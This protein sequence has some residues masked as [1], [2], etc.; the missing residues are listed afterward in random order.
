MGLSGLLCSL[1]RFIEN[2]DRVLFSKTGTTNAFSFLIP[3]NNESG[4]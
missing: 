4:I 3:E 2:R 1:D